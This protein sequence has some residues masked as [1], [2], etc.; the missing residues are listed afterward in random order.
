MR[1]MGVA[2]AALLVTLALG[3]APAHGQ[4]TTPPVQAGEASPPA[5][6]TFRDTYAH[7]EVL[8]DATWLV[9]HLHDPNVRILDARMPFEAALY[10]TGHIPGAVYLDVLNQFCCASRIMGPEAF[11][12]LMGRLGV[13]G[14]TTVVVYDTDG[15]L[16]AARLWWA[17]RYYGHE[18]ARVF[19]GGLRE[20]LSMGL[21]LETDTTKV[22]PAVFTP[23]VQPQWRAT[24]D[25]VRAAIDDPDVA[26]VDALPWPVFTGDSPDFGVG[27]IPTSVSLPVF[28]TLDGIGK[29]VIGPDV[30]SRM[31]ARLGLDPAQR[32]IT[33]CGG[34]YAGATDAYVLYLMGFDRVGLYDGSLM[35]W[36]SDPANPMET[37]P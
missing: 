14:D 17:L 31:L 30:L 22:E 28:D 13:G 18:D 8:A 4:E 26:L 19:G 23:E 25:E 35:E 24:I 34:G 9:S 11:A 32:T 3:G 1:R 6:F 37:V 16:W 15:G 20:W 33:Y 12:A 21:A 29:G 36:T 27:H 10:P 5:S 7:P 2:A